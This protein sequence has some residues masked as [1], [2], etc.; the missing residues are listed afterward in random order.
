MNSNKDR[1]EI[2][3]K[4]LCYLAMSAG[5]EEILNLGRE[6]I[7]EMARKPAASTEKAVVVKKRGRG[8]PIGSIGKPEGSNRRATFPIE[9]WVD[10][11]FKIYGVHKDKSAE[12]LVIPSRNEYRIILD[13]MSFKNL[14]KAAGYVASIKY[15]A[16][17]LFW[18][19]TD[20]DGKLR[21]V[22]DLKNIPPKR[23]SNTQVEATS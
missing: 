1:R 15:L 2:L 13:G 18:K 22:R 9:R 19:Y 8:R 3:K 6:I 7:N 23:H 14:S 10:Y 5:I 16:G 17:G 11:P 21:P 4:D 20:E 12:A